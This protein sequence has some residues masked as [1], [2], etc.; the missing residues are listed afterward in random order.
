MKPGLCTGGLQVIYAAACAIDRARDFQKKTGKEG[1]A[2][3][4]FMARTVRQ[5]SKGANNER[6]D[7]HGA[8]ARDMVI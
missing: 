8:D 6:L 2:R 3:F 7:Q 5:G 4:L 1:F